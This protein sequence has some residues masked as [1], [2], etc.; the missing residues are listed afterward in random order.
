M[1][2]ETLDLILLGGNVDDPG[3]FN[4]CI[5]IEIRDGIDK[6]LV[7][8]QVKRVQSFHLIGKMGKAVGQTV[9][10]RR[11]GKASVPTRGTLGDSITLD[12]HDVSPW[13]GFLGMQ[14]RPQTRE[15]TPHDH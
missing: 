14:C 11:V 12:E 10:E 6:A 2:A 4:S 1:L 13:V 8:F 15:P 5:D 3:L 7:V 9:G